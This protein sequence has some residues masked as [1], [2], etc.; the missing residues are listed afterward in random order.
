MK[1]FVLSTSAKEQDTGNGR[2]IVAYGSRALVENDS[3]NTFLC[4]PQVKRQL[5]VCGDKV[6]FAH[7]ATGNSVIT[8]ILERDSLIER[9]DASGRSKPLAANL[10]RLLIVCSDPPGIQPL[11]IDR[12]LVLAET[13]NIGAVLLFHKSDIFDAQRITD[14]ADIYRNLGYPVCLTSAKLEG[15]LDCLLKEL[16]EHTG[17]LVGPSGVGKSSIIK[18]LIGDADIRIGALSERSGLGK[19]TTTTASLYKLP[20]GGEL[21]DSPGIRDFLIPNLSSEQIAMGYKEFRERAIGCKF[22]NCS[23]MHE[24]KCAVQAAVEAGEISQSRWITY[25]AQSNKL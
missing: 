14:L 8:A 20:A 4:V 1:C 19:H 16:R 25:Q 24:P 23:H 18:Q 11:L 10:D 2:V 21:I 9:L 5:I 22:K 3:G 6:T 12:Y 13:Q 17:I 15:G 7:Q